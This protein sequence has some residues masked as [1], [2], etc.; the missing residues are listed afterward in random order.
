MSKFVKNHL[1]DQV[2]SDLQGVGDVLVVSLTGLSANTNYELRKRLRSKKIHLRVVKNSLARRATEG[3]VLAPAFVGLTGP[4]AV[5]W[6]GEDI[7][8]LAKEIIAIG[9]EKDFKLVAPKG[10]AMD[11]SPLSADDV[12]KV[13]AWPSRAEQLSILA[14]QICGVASTLSGQLISAGGALASQIKQ[15]SEGEEAP[16]APAEGAAPAPDAAP[17]AAPA[18]T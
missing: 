4:A 12:K 10:G 9:K 2:K 17:P 1:T 18:A 16:A 5:V 3:T 6:G 14:G 11:G 8:S 15:K 7:V 13:S